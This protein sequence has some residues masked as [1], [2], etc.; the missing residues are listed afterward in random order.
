MEVSVRDIAAVIG[1]AS[2]VNEDLRVSQLLTDS[3]QLLD[4]AKTLFFAIAAHRRDGHDFIPELYDKG[5]R[6]FVVTKADG[7]FK[8]LAGANFLG[9]KDSLKALQELA[10]WHRSK[11]NIPV[12]GITGSNGKTIVK[13][14][15]A[16]YAPPGAA[17][18]PGNPATTLD[19]TKSPRR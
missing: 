19:L 5:V 3:R 2:P 11:F 8:K 12:I 17:E 4:P 15:L 6:N 18:G 7:F 14:W 16:Q 10:A 1:T 13:E 9:V